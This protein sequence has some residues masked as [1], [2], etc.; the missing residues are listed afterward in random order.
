[1]YKRPPE[2]RN[3]ST[4]TCDALSRSQL[5]AAAN[6]MQLTAQQMNRYVQHHAEE[7]EFRGML[8]LLEAM[9]YSA[10][11]AALCCWL[12]RPSRR[13]YREPLE[14]LAVREHIDQM[15]ALRRRLDVIEDLLTELE[16]CSP[17]TKAKG[18]RLTWTPITGG[19]NER[20]LLRSL[21]LREMRN[22][23]TCSN[24]NSVVQ[25]GEGSTCRK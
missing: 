11:F 25:S 22:Y 4:G 23:P 12:I 7:N 3:S 10:A 21:L 18:F 8:R 6:R 15:Q 16:T 9:E 17:D 24:A 13:R 2:R 1:M 19:Q 5:E 14:L 20:E